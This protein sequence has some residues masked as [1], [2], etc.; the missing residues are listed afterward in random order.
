MVRLIRATLAISLFTFTDAQGPWP[1]GTCTNDSPEP[2]IPAPPP[3][4]LKASAYAFPII[5]LEKLPSKA[6]SPLEKNST[7]TKGTFLGLTGAILLVRYTDTPVGPYDELS[8]IP[9]VFGYIKTNSDGSR[10]P[11]A[12]IRGTRFYVSQK[13]TNWNGR[14]NWNIPKHLAK[15]VWT[16]NTDGSSSV[17]IYPYDTTGD[18]HESTPATLPFFQASF[19][20]VTPTIPLPINTDIL[21]YLGL[22]PPLIQAPLPAG[23]GSYGELPGTT[24][25]AETL[26]GMS[27]DFSTPGIF[28]MYQG[29]GDE[30]G[31]SGFNAVGDEYFPNFWPNIPRYNVGI[32][33]ENATIS[34]PVPDKWY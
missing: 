17:K 31:D 10:T 7:A 15:F 19:S 28:D 29:A 2:I 4:I 33:M 21:R 9:G 16:D 24:Q 12:S 26:L 22:S 34:F 8:I 32:K 27:S 18:P 13:Y 6:Y 5:P 23:D 20:P 14:V 11:K 30:V 3:W 25:W 1:C